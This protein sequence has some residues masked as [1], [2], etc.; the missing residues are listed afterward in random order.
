MSHFIYADH[1][2][3]TAVSDT[4]L[5]A[6]LPHF[7]TAY[8][9]PSSLYRFAQEGKTDL[10]RARAEIA[11]CLNA[12][13]EEIY[14]TSGGTEADNWA[15]RGVAE[16][17]ALKGR[18]GGHIIT[19]AIEHH[20]VLHTAQYLEKQGYEVTYL[21]VDGR[22][23]VD[24]AALEGAIRPDTILISIMAAN[25]EIGTI[26]PVAELGRI[27]R[28]HKV[29]FHTD[30][31]QAVG[32]IPVDVRK[33]DVDAFSLSGHKFHGPRGIGALY[34]REGFSIP[35]LIA[36][37][38]QERGERAGTENLAGIV[39][40]AAA[41]EEA[42]EHLTADMTRISTLRDALI[43][44]LMEHVD[45]LTPT[46]APIAAGLDDRL[47]SIASFTCDDVDG[48]LLVVLLDR[49]GVAAATG[50][51]CSTGST[52]PS[53]VLTAMGIPAPTARGALRLSLASNVTAEDIALLSERVPT[54]IRKARLI[55][56]M[57]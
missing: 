22:G 19:S 57:Q 9:N 25:N 51:A 40:M 46:G 36:G 3:T 21:P 37:G 2:A 42:C 33:L 50:S 27:A 23:L 34:L 56:G 12:R 8:G 54:C 1:A 41:L 4:A 35:P 30:A 15:L 45:G 48:E 52:E 24:P 14:F 53:H 39:G 7:T 16:L 13:P 28:A 55:S 18:K 43:G 20:A 29:L 17:M 44:H 26:E 31:V 38:A 5:Q 6:M 10:E 32:H 47:P 49:A 11:A